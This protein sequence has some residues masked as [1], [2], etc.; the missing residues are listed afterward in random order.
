MAIRPSL[1]FR[2]WRLF[3]IHIRRRRARIASTAR[4][5]AGCSTRASVTLAKAD[6]CG[7]MR[8]V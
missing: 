4:L 6:F 1:A 3:A 5:F 8:R 7:N 2:D